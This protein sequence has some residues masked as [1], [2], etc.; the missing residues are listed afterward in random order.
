MGVSA[1]KRILFYAM[2]VTIASLGLTFGGCSSDDSSTNPVGID[3]SKVYIG[4]LLSASGDWRDLGQSA[5]AS[6]S[7]A[8][9]EMNDTLRARG[10]NFR[11]AV[12][13]EDTQLNP[14]LALQRLELFMRDSI[15]F[16]IGPQSSAEAQTILNYANTHKITL[17]SPSATASS[18]AVPSDYLFRLAPREASEAQ[19]V[20]QRIFNTGVRHIVA[21][22]ADDAGNMGLTTAMVN[23]FTALGDGAT[24]VS[25]LR[26]TSQTEYPELVELLS[27]E[28]NLLKSQY[29]TETIAVLI[30]GFDNSAS[31]LSFADEDETLATVAWFAGDGVAQNSAVVNN[32]AAARFAVKVNLRAAIFDVTDAKKAQYQHLIDTVTKITGFAPN[33]FALSCYDAVKL[34]CNAYLEKGR[35][36]SREDLQAAMVAYAAT[37]NGVTGSAKFD[38]NGDREESYFAFY[39]VYQKINGYYA[40]RQ[41]VSK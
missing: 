7:V 20:A 40:W 30:N 3:T 36:A 41:E 2:I 34:I 9:S 25:D 11:L 39:K 38:V 17:I 22:S 32:T 26:M 18:L 15:Y 23:A 8:L 37:Y 10:A 29:P 12:R 24:A 35:K 13:D 33:A 28:V 21:V 14:D 4:T 1:M 27:A 31:L 16:V 5:I 6:I 19:T